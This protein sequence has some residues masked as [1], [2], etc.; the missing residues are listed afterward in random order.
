[1]LGDLSKDYLKLTRESFAEIG[2]KFPEEINPRN[3][4]IIT[5]N[6]DGSLRKSVDLPSI[7]NSDRKIGKTLRSLFSLDET[8][9][10]GNLEKRLKEKYKNEQL[11]V[12][13]MFL[14]LIL[15]RRNI[16]K[17][18]SKDF[19]GNTIAKNE[20]Q[21]YFI[22]DFNDN[23]VY[24]KFGH[25]NHIGQEFSILVKFSLKNKLINKIEIVDSNNAH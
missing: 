15:N 24:V 2:L 20:I 11:V 5:Y 14:E 19:H 7:T 1:M 10:I 23:E 3:G 25:I 6:N 8:E 22:D 4:L 13:I 16:S 17:Y 21:F 12:V 9:K 18:L